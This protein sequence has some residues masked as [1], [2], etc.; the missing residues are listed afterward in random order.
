[1]TTNNV[2]VE[3]HPKLIQRGS[4]KDIKKDFYKN[5]FKMGNDQCDYRSVFTSTIGETGKNLGPRVE[6][7]KL[8]SSKANFTLGN[9]INDYQS[10]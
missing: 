1:M 10:T 6:K 2:L 4:Q 7:Q 3:S 8:P 9:D 5:N